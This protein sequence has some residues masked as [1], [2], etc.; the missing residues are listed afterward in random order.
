MIILLFTGRSHYPGG[1]YRDFKGQFNSVE[2]AEKNLTKS[3]DWA[4]I[5]ELKNNEMIPVKKFLKDDIHQY[6]N[7]WKERKI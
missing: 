4:D 3:D 5:V 7:N 2:E 6:T 1:G